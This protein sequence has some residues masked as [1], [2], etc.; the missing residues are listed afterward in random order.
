MRWRPEQSDLVLAAQL[1]QGLRADRLANPRQIKRFL[2]AFGV[3]EAVAGSRGVQIPADVLVKMLLL[4]DQ[5]RSSFE[6][7]AAT[8]GV[9]RAAMLQHWEDW[10]AGE[11]GSPTDPPVGIAAETLHW[12]QAPP[13]LSQIELGNYLNLAASLLNVSIGAAISDATISLVR[14]LL[15]ESQ[16]DREDAAEELGDR[17]LDEQRA[18]ISVLF[19]EAL[20][21]DDAATVITGACLWARR[22]PDLVDPITTRIRADCWGARLT[23]GGVV[24]L[25]GTGV[26]QFKALVRQAATDFSLD[27]IVR[28]AAAE[29]IDSFRGN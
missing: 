20:R 8:S 2:N 27:A 17:P 16:V 21:T 12:A 23:A 25:A 15:S 1:A 11:D 5:H 19:G 3:R 29:E 24:E 28:S 4:E 10:A 9:D 7:L 6:T 13:F 22:A 14:R 18:A 26:D